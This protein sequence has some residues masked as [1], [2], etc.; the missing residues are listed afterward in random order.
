MTRAISEARY[1]LTCLTTVL[2]T[3]FAT[4]GALGPFSSIYETTRFVVLAIATGAA[5]VFLTEFRGRS[6]S[7]IAGFALFVGFGLMS[8][9]LNGVTTAR[10]ADFFLYVLYFLA[11]WLVAASYFERD[12]SWWARHLNWLLAAVGISLFI[13]ACLSLTIYVWF[14]RDGGGRLDEHIP[15]GFI[16]IRYWSHLATWFLPLVPILLWQIRQQNL[17][18]F[19][20]WGAFFGAGIWV[21]ILLLTTSRGSMVSIFL[22]GV[23]VTLFMGQ[24]G[25]LWLR[26]MLKIVVAG[27]IA[28]LLL[29]Y[30]VLEWIYPVEVVFRQLHGTSSGRVDLWL[31]AWDLSLQNFPLGIGP[32]GWISPEV[33]S[34]FGHPHNMILMWAAEWGWLAVVGLLMIVASTLGRFL[35]LR[36]ALTQESDLGQ[37]VR[38]AGLTASVIAGLAHAQLSAVFIAPPS[39]LVGFW[40]LALFMAV[41]WRPREQQTAGFA[42]S[43]GRG[44]ILKMGVAYLVL[45]VGLSIGWYAVLDYY[46]YMVQKIYVDQELYPMA[47][48]FWLH[49]QV[50][51]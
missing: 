2:S 43:P 17:S 31:K 47:P 4:L 1:E 5:L 9:L 25:R 27:L 23:T 20:Q 28:W 13:Y 16:N 44:Q 46:E 39:M 12:V 18:T 29:S 49:G 14:L 45:I 33:G 10:L 36:Q 51:N 41:V 8:F 37:S 6:F 19:I 48:R 24:A 21:W 15:Y 22:A 3:L 50:Q 42:S 38:V 40:I 11:I 34:R 7:V 30:V 32:L 26:D 35:K